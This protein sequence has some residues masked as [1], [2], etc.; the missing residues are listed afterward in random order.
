MEKLEL[1]AAGGISPVR[2][3]PD[4]VMGTIELIRG[5]HCTTVH[6]YHKVW[7]CDTD[8]E[9]W[10]TFEKLVYLMMIKGKPQMVR[11]EGNL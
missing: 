8:L 9:V 4:L 3:D 2:T 11:N 1:V 10:P 6:V 7:P 5:V